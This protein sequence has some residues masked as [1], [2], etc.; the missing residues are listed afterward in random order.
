MFFYRETIVNFATVGKNDG[1]LILV[2]D[3]VHYLFKR[4]FFNKDVVLL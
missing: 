1:F 2:T 4:V 3:F